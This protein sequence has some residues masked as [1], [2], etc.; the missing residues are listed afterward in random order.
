MGNVPKYKIYSICLKENW[1]A[2][3][4]G[5]ELIEKSWTE[6]SVVFTHSLIHSFSVSVS[7]PCYMFS[8]WGM[9]E[10]IRSVLCL[11]PLCFLRL[12]LK[13]YMTLIWTFE[14]PVQIITFASESSLQPQLYASYNKRFDKRKRNV[15]ESETIG[16]FWSNTKSRYCTCDLIQSST[17]ICTYVNSLVIFVLFLTVA[18]N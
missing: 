8:I 5:I 16:S 10:D 12:G 9:S 18:M 2:D 11:S 17:W 1:Q 7:V 4:I 14:I 3:I 6:I 15:G 13:L